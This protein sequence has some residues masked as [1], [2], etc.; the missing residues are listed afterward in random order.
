M[1]HGQMYLVII[2]VEIIRG[3]EVYKFEIKHTLKPAQMSLEKC[4]V[5]LLR[6]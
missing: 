3:M 4:W 1:L 6:F 5:Q 2:S